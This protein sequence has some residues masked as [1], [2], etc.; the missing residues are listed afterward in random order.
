[1]KFPVCTGFFSADGNELIC[2]YL[3]TPLIEYDVLT[4]SYVSVVNDDV[5]QVNGAQWLPGGNLCTIQA[6]GNVSIW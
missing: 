1:M 2:T 6:S 3:S 4:H 5:G